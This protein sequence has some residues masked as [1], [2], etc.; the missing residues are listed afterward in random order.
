LI[1]LSYIFM[2]TD[3]FIAYAITLIIFTLCWCF[4]LLLMPLFITMV[5]DDWFFSFRLAA[6]SFISRFA[7]GHYYFDFLR[8]DGFLWCHWYALILSLIFLMP[9]LFDAIGWPLILLLPLRSF[10][11][12]F[13][14]HYAIGYA[15][16]NI[17]LLI[18]LAYCHL[19]HD[20]AIWYYYFHYIILRWH[21][22][23]AI[24]YCCFAFIHW[25]RVIT[26]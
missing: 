16:F 11:L 10:I 26:Y 25:I 7:D 15:W 9:L 4:T 8:H 3:Y 17:M 19:R 6:I 1:T 20:F 23:T 21:Y 14:F 5:I 24:L 2:F 22:Y 13:Y 12:I 18:S